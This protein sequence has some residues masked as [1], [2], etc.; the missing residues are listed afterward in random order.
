MEISPKPSQ[1]AS[2]YTVYGPGIPYCE[3]S[4]KIFFCL[5]KYFIMNL[6]KATL[7]VANQIRV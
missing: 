6:E 2:H 3:F 1:K 4:K 7:G 5:H